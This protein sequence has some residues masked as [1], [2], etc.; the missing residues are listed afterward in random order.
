MEQ[1]KKL[2]THFCLGGGTKWY[3]FNISSSS[4]ACGCFNAQTLLLKVELDS[5]FKGTHPQVLRPPTTEA[6]TKAR[7]TSDP[8]GASA[9]KNMGIKTGHNGANPP[10]E[11]TAR[12]V[13]PAIQPGP[14]MI[15][16]CTTSHNRLAPNDAAKRA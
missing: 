8:K 13:Q 7:I 15:E 6:K 4:S 11:P 12:A 9:A 10:K 2:G 16:F 5:H 3:G 1:P 14:R